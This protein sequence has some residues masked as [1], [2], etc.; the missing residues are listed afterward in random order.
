M[1]GSNGY[2]PDHQGAR[3]VNHVHRGNRR[4]NAAINKLLESITNLDSNVIELANAM[5]T[6]ASP[7]VRE[8]L[9]DLVIAIIHAE[10][11]AY[12]I[13]GDI[14]EGPLNAMRLRDMLNTYGLQPKP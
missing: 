1:Y 11:D 4:D 9:M 13:E 7:K 14:S 6:G 10:C 8:R 5:V 3:L 12:E 2:R